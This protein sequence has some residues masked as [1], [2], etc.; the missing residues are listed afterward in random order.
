LEAAQPFFDEMQKQKKE[1]EH[2]AARLHKL[3]QL[4]KWAAVFIFLLAII[5]LIV[6]FIQQA[7]S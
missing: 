6:F 1:N 2:K 3:I 7:S 4:T 5:L